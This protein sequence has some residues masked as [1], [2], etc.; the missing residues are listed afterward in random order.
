MFMLTDTCGG[1]NGVTNLLPSDHF[2]GNLIENS[3]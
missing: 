1:L 2:A 3:G